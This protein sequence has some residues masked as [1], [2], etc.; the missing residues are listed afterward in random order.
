MPR[1]AAQPAAT[2]VT[3]GAASIAIGN[4]DDNSDKAQASSP[5]MLPTL[6]SGSRLRLSADGSL[7]DLIGSVAVNGV[8]STTL[9]SS[10]AIFVCA[11]LKWWHHEHDFVGRFD[12]VG[13][14]DLTA[15]QIYPV[16]LTDYTVN[17]NNPNGRISIDANG[18]DV[19]VLSAGGSVTMHAAYIDQGGNLRAPFGAIDLQADKELTLKPGSITST[20][21]QG[22]TTLFGQ[23]ELGKDWVYL[24]NI[25]TTNAK[26]R[27]V[28]T[29]PS[30]RD[31]DPL[32]SSQVLLQAP[33]V[34]LQP[35]AVIDQSGGGDL[36]AYEFEPGLSGTVDVNITQAEAMRWCRG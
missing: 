12:S 15:R 26:G 27:L 1:H 29:K 11:V 18:S 20:S 36:L 25:L 28:F 17:I 13:G 22:V 34:R 6:G 3:G 9:R 32:P 33:S 31:A 5:Q 14:L 7:I 23:V 4:S 21:L 24:L 10:T 35:G 19:P 16:T 30:N 8:Q 2:T